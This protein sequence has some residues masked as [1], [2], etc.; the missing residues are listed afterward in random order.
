VRRTGRHG[1]LNWLVARAAAK[2]SE[3]RGQRSVK[4]I[5]PHSWLLAT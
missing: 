2:R 5:V 1:A 3:I 4:P